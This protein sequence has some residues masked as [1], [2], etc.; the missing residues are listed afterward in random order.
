[1]V[2]TVCSA[3][4]YVR[5]KCG[6][7]SVSPGKV[8]SLSIKTDHAFLLLEIMQAEQLAKTH[9]NVMLFS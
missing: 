5:V 9:C 2:P 3:I 8:S 4:L 7:F 6:I 1:M